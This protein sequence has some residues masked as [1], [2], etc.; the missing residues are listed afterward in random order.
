MVIGGEPRRYPRER[1]CNKTQGEEPD[2]VI[3]ML[4]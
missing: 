3:Y 1:E 4:S 2:Q